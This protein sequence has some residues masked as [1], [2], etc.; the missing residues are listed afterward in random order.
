MVELQWKC[1]P[2]RPLRAIFLGAEL[3]MLVNW[4]WALIAGNPGPEASLWGFML[5]VVVP[6]MALML[7][8]IHWSQM[9]KRCAPAQYH[10]RSIFWST[11]ALFAVFLLWPTH[12]GDK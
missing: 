9:E 5:F 2:N 8:I 10:Y 1:P 4:I 7:S 12:R 6:L 3:L 11:V